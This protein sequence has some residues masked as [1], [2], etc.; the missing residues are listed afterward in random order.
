MRQLDDI[1]LENVGGSGWIGGDINDV[2]EG[3]ARSVGSFFGSAV[4]TIARGGV[5]VVASTGAHVASTTYRGV[6]SIFRGIFG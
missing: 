3:P 6:T 4:G 5:N 1:D 2:L